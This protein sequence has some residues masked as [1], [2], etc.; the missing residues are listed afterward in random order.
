MRA[1]EIVADGD[2][3][4]GREPACPSGWAEN[5]SWLITQT[6]GSLVAIHGEG[7]FRRSVR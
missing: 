7:R 6:V 1:L 4:R 3:A 5:S 2:Q